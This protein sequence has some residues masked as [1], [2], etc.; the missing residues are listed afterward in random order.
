PTAVRW[1]KGPLHDDIAAAARV[2]AADV[3]VREGDYEVLVVAVGAMVRTG[4]EVS[5]KLRAEGY[6]VTLVDPRWVKPV[7]EVLVD[8]AAQHRLVVTVEDNVRTGGFG[9]ALVTALADAQVRTPAR[10]HAIPPRFLQHDSRD[11]IL[12][13]VGLTADAITQDTVDILRQDG[14]N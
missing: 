2:G 7:E 13:E 4:V 8:L 10:V 1:P 12:A 6:G 9:S 11:T 3:I 14:S 5:E